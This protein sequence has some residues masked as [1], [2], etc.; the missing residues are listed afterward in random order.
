MK[1]KICFSLWSSK[2]NDLQQPVSCYTV[3]S[4]GMYLILLICP[5]LY[6]SL[7]IPTSF[8]ICMIIKA[9]IEGS[10]L[11]PADVKVKLSTKYCRQDC[12]SSKS[13]FAEGELC[14]SKLDS[15]GPLSWL[16]SDVFHYVV[17]KNFLT[18][19]VAMTYLENLDLICWNFPL[20]HSHYL[21]SQ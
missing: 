19:L 6:E 14:S 20:A 5:W 7:I 10:D 17:K 13:V 18:F 3:V 4:L 11:I 15:S 9:V 8:R 1:S 2:A 16:S 12:R 21:T